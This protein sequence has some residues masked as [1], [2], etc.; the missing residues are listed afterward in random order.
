MDRVDLLVVQRTLKSLFQH[1]SSKASILQ[2]SA[3]FIAQLSYPYMT[4]RKNPNLTPKETDPDFPVSV[5][6]SPAEAWV[7]GGLLWGRGH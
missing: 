7:G 1:H 5:Q 6:E 3:F 4:T 2:H